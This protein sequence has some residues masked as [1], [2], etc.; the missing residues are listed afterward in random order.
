M[1]DKSKKFPF[2]AEGVVATNYSKHYMIILISVSLGVP[3]TIVIL[4]GFNISKDITRTCPNIPFPNILCRRESLS[5]FATL[6]GNTALQHTLYSL[7][8]SAESKPL[9][10][11]GLD[12]PE[13]WK[14]SYIR[15]FPFLVRSV[16]VQNRQPLSLCYSPLIY[17]HLYSNHIFEV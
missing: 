3:R 2:W 12:A 13:D 16:V 4:H 8:T 6:W 11:T 9:I 7:K 10:S 17:T 1:K 5:S 15:K 14:V